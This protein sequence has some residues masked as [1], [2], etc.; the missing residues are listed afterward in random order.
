MTPSLKNILS[1]NF[2]YPFISTPGISNRKKNLYFAFSK[3]KCSINNGNA[4]FL[5][6]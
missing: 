6:S 4:L 5:L 2:K 1:L 3:D